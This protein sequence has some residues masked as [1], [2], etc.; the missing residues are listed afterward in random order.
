MRR[1][2][3]WS[4]GVCA[5]LS[6][7]LGASGCGD[8]ETTTSAAG[9]SSSS[10]A[11]TTSQGSGG[12]GGE[13]T[14][15]AGG[16]GGAG[17][18][19]GLSGQPFTSK[20]ESSYETQTSLA[21]DGKGGLVAVWI[22]FFAD[23]TSGVGYSVSRD[24]GKSFT[25]PAVIQSPDGRLASNPVVVADSKGKFSLAW[26]GFRPDFAMP[27]EHVY[28]AQLD[29]KT[30]TFGAPAVASDDGSQTTLDFDKPSIK[31]DASDDLLVTWA[32]FS[33][34]AM[35]G[36][37]ALVLARS[38]DGATFTRSEITSDATFGNLAYLCLDTSLGAGA[39]LYLVHLGANGTVTLRTSTNKGQSWE[40]RATPASQVLFHDITCAAKGD[41]VWVAY[42]SGTALFSPGE[43]PPADA[44]YVM[45]SPDGGASFD[46]PVKVTD[47]PAGDQYL[48][49]QLARSPSGKLAVVYYQGV[50]DGPGNLMLASS[51]NGSAWSAS[52]VASIGTFTVDRTIASWLG[53]YVG[54]AIPAEAG[55]TTYAENSENKAHVRFAEIA[56]P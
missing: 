46:P 36:P 56:L 17:R 1:F 41:D 14:G 54:F 15:G 47:G 50:V 4:F 10:A 7:A 31:V 39:P 8:D 35:G 30:E 26:L 45:R 2:A 9:S 20:G 21:A 53:A 34:T 5:A 16:E 55:F 51:A 22:A 12:A 13:G 33:A 18:G 38:S 28:V 6:S 32:D 43:D 52:P 48:F 37:A 27:D 11:A 3:W 24:G 19:G 25:D 29:A 49:P 44:V 40:L 42:A 23:T